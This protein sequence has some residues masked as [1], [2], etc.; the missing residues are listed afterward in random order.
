MTLRLL[1]TATEVYPNH[2]NAFMLWNHCNQAALRYLFTN[3]MLGGGRGF[4]Q[5]IHDDLFFPGQT[6]DKYF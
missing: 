2:T 1:Y 4:G 6:A 3:D 5:T